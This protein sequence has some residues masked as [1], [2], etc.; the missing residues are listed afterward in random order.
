M[1]SVTL[2]KIGVHTQ[3]S[4]PS[5][6]SALEI[7]TSAQAREVSGRVQIDQSSRE[8]VTGCLRLL[9]REFY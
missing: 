8:E 6:G 2:I 1:G 5:N 4:L 3:K 9:D 7:P